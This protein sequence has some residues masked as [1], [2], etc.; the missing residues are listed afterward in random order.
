MRK[1]PTQLGVLPSSL[2]RADM[3]Y[4]TTEDCMPVQWAPQC[5]R[6]MGI[7]KKEMEDISYG[8]RLRELGLVSVGKRRL[9]R[10][11]SICINP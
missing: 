8:E 2:S 4:E 7:L 3:R 11:L 9:G 1:K 5:K 10:I 6:D